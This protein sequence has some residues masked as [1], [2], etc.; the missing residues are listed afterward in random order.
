M[1][2]VGVSVADLIFCINYFILYPSQ[3]RSGD[4]LSRW[5]RQCRYD[6]YHTVPLQALL[7]RTV[8]KEFVTIKIICLCS[9]V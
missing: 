1:E 9:V 6:I 2:P 8:E 3:K 7:A 5:S 4:M